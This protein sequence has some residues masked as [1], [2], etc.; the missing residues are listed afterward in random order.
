MA[1]AGAR[2]AGADC[3]T[4]QPAAVIGGGFKSMREGMSIVEHGAQPGF[5]AFVAGHH[6]RLEPATAQ[7]HVLDR[8]RIALQ[9]RRDVGFEVG[10]ERGVEDIVRRASVTDPGI[11]PV[12]RR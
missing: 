10:K 9:D 2:H 3:F 5:L 4:M 8:C 6:I 12:R 7:D 11:S 1:S